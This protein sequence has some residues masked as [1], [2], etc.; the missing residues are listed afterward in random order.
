M[1]EIQRA[2]PDARRRAATLFLGAAAAGLLVIWF[3]QSRLPVLEG[4]LAENPAE[5]THRIRL[6]AA[7]TGGIFAIPTLIFAA[8]FWKYGNQILRAGRFPPAGTRVVRD[9]P[10]VIGAQARIRGRALQAV[11][12]SLVV[13][14]IMLVAVW[15]HVA[16]ILTA[17]S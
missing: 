14:D 3:L 2:E 8:Q 1:T 12:V 11:A 9:T 17:S 5:A 4:W 10:V 6:L 16:A 15:C 13:L 7:L